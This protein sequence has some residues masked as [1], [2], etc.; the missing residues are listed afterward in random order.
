MHAA[1]NKFIARF[2]I[3]GV[4]TAALLF[5]ALIPAGFMP[6]QGANGEIVMQ[7]C[8]GFATKSVSVSFDDDGV[9]ATGQSSLFDSSPCG[10]AASA[11]PPVLPVSALNVVH[12][13]VAPPVSSGHPPAISLASILRSQ[14]P[15]AP[16]ALV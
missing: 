12:V 4:L 16:P 7:L 14:S 6:A 2:P 1:I 9:P 5:R 8:S 10:F 11:A 3:L 13:P 15:R